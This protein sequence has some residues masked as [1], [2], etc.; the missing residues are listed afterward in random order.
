M[1]PKLLAGEVIADKAAGTKIRHDPLAVRDARRCGRAAFP[2]EV[3]LDL[4]GRSF[5]PPGFLSIRRAISNR[6][7]LVVLE[8][9][10]D[11]LV[12]CD[13][14]RGKPAGTGEFPPDV[15]VRADFDR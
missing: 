15:L 1:L 12:P 4:P 6:V 2:F 14:R 8:G 7:E 9:R 11:E 5:F 10:D 3:R 13:D